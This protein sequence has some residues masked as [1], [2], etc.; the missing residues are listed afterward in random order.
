MPV[1]NQ[2]LSWAKELQQAVNSVKKTDIPFAAHEKKIKEEISYFTDKFIAAAENGQPEETK[3]I[4]DTLLSLRAEMTALY[5]TKPDITE[6]SIEKIMQAFV[7]DCTQLAI[8]GDH[9]LTSR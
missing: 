2:E 5:L 4:F 1:T 3:K 7:E 8:A 6:K 9:L